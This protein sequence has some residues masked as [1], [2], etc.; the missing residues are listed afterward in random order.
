MSGRL[1]QYGALAVT[2]LVTVLLA[3]LVLSVNQRADEAA[4]AA[5]RDDRVRAQAMLAGLTQQYLQFTFLEISREAG[6]RAWSLA[7]GDAT[8]TVALDAWVK[9]SPL[10]FVGAALTDLTGAPLGATGRVARDGTDP[11]WAPLR[12]SLAANQPGL[13]GV[14]QTPDGPLVA[15]AVPVTRA[16]TPA[17]LFV[18]FAD[19]RTW[20]L[21]G[22]TSRLDLGRDGRYAIV[23]GTGVATA[24]NDPARVGTTVLDRSVSGPLLWVDNGDVV[25]AAP[26]GTAGWTSIT[27]QPSSAFYSPLGSARR[28]LA[29]ALTA[30]LAVLLLGLG[31]AEFRRKRALT[32]L[33]DA[34]IFDP[35]TGAATRRLLDLRL[36]AAIARH[37]RSG[38]P[39]AVLFCDLDRFKPVND[40]HGHAA[41]DQVLKQVAD[42]FRE[43]L[44]D[45][46]FLARVG[47][48]EFVVVLESV[49]DG[50]DP[51]EVAQRLI[52]SL[53]TPIPVGDDTVT[54]GVSVGVAVLGR[55]EAESDAVLHAADAAMYRAKQAQC[56]YRV[57][58]LD[59]SGE[60]P[61]QRATGAKHSDLPPGR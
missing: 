1:R 53:Q 45:E 31:V 23:D 28:W 44:R 55:Q 29:P 17:G 33:A 21:Q 40:G 25:S 57:I 59:D 49:T 10:H 47:G 30:L 14:F 34:A 22:Y 39:V 41:G 16:K 38:A 9:G 58:H 26:V 51:G 7:R 61:A 46:D 18:A 52:E 19:L 37:R 48:D 50:G 32:R 54:I 2:L 15:F 12:A 13:S 27:R 24:S 6:G 3:V 56:G 43:N 11:A 5:Q 8:D 35:L 42:R 36:S 20:P 4:R 60:V